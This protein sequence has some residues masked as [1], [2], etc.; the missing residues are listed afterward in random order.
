MKSFKTIFSSVSLVAIIMALALSNC[1]GNQ[2]TLNQMIPSPIEVIHET[3]STNTP[4]ILDSTPR[5]SRLATETE[6][7]GMP[8][9][10]TAIPNLTNS[11]TDLQLNPSF[12]DLAV[13]VTHQSDSL[14]FC[15]F[16]QYPGQI[17]SLKYPYSDTQWR[18][19][20]S[21]NAYY[22]PVWSPDG[23]MLAA[24]SVA[25]APPTK[26]TQYPEALVSEYPEN[27]RIWLISPDGLTKR[28]ISQAYTRYQTN[29]SEGECLTSGLHGLLK[30]SADNQWLA[31]D[32][33]SFLDQIDSFISF[34]NVHTGQHYEMQ[35]EIADGVWT[36]N[37]N[38]FAMIVNS[39]KEIILVEVKESGIEKSTFAYPSA[40]GETV[41]FTNLAWENNDKIILIGKQRDATN[42]FELW[43]LGTTNNQWSRRFTFN[44]ENTVYVIDLNSIALCEQ[45]D[46]N[47]IDLFNVPNKFIEARINKPSDIDCYS[48]MPVIQQNKTI[49]LSYFS[50]P[51]ATEIWYSNLSGVAQRVLA[52]K[53]FHFPED[54]EVGSIS[55]RP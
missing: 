31:V 54:Y 44:R 15:D 38:T 13:E 51:H 47:T 16:E 14:F 34:I 29:T 7:P 50:S 39:Q 12:P 22:H 41:H 42:K 24:I 23:S 27:E 21:K 37:Q 18:L 36:L 17:W 10:E 5:P 6:I 33:G 32:Y 9:R 52:I 4:V 35:N 45:I 11:G 40:V 8:V 55:W 2:P 20:D 30:W 19:S 3:T 46:N 49:G 25:L 26:K 28:Q 53:D 1:S 43:E 48:I